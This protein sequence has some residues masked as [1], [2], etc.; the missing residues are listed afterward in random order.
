[1]KYTSFGLSSDELLEV[2]ILGFSDVGL[3]LDFSGGEDLDL[4][5]TSGFFNFTFELL[6]SLSLGIS[7]GEDGQL[8]QSEVGFVLDQV[9][10]VVVGKAKSG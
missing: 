2:V 4:F 8:S 9:L 3:G 6:L 1:M 5:S 7:L 10:L